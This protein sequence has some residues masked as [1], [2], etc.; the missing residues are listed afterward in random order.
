VFTTMLG[1][2]AHAIEEGLD[3]L[4]SRDEF[5]I[6]MVDVLEALLVAPSHLSNGGEAS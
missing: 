2:R 4:L 1:E 5:A 6:H 3:L